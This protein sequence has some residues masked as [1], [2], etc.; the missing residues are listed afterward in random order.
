MIGELTD[1][2]TYAPWSPDDIRVPAVAIH[3][4]LG[5][6]HHGLSTAYLGDHLADVEVVVIDGARHF[7]PNTHPDAVAAVVTDLAG[8]TSPS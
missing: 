8:R 2:T 5:A 1:L 3:G 4:S 6:A 7:G